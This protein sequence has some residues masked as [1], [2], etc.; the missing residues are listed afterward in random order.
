MHS[1]EKLGE[2]AFI[3]S[4]TSAFVAVLDDIPIAVL[5]SLIDLT[6]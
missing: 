2:Q 3:I 4:A 5:L 1:T 6:L